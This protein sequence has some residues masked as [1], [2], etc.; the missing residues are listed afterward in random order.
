MRIGIASPIEVASLEK[1]F[2]NIKPNEKSLGLG[3]T[4]VNIII[5]GLIQAGHKVVVF[6]LDANVKGK[7]VME[8]ENLKIIFGNFRT[9]SISKLLDFCSK[10][11]KQI[12]QFIEEE[13]DNLDIVNAH[14]TYEFAIGTI[15]AKVPHLI[16]FRDDSPTILRLTKHPYRLVRLL[17]DFWV[18]RKGKAFSYNSP[19]LK[20][21]IKLD[22]PVIPNPIRDSEI[23]GSRK[24]PKGKSNMIICYIGNGWDYRK[25]PDTAILAFSKLLKKIPNIELHLIGGGCENGGA[26]YTR[27][28]NLGLNK[29]VV[30]RG[31]LPHHQLMKEL[32]GFDIM[33]HTAREESFGNNLIEAMAKGIPVLGGKNSGAVPWVL[34]DEGCL[35]DIE[36]A[37]NVSDKLEKMILDENYYEELSLNGLINI[38]ER[39]SQIKVSFNYVEEYLKIISL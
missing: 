35:A 32:D 17:M 28:E 34:G 11:F 25:N 16:T 6:S 27:M 9:S 13:R 36:D 31:S 15:L 4:A 2:P 5:D 29:N 8:G 38:N 24:Y 20:S 22:G 18:R 3:G 7:Y 19:Y 37:E 1:H 12:K 23:V 10:E 14:W 21:L 30:Y 39:F 26:G 33:L